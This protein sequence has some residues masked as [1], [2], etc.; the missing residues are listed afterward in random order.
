[1]SSQNTN[2]ESTKRESTKDDSKDRISNPRVG[3]EIC[4][5]ADG[6]MIPRFFFAF[7]PSFFRDKRVLQ[8]INGAIGRMLK[9]D[10]DSFA[11]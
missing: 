5:H 11:E 3:P 8:S 7:R 9:T 1:V 4:K 10:S 2:H 6:R